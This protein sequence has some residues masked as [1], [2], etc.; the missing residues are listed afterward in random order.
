MFQAGAVEP[1]EPQA[2]RVVADQDVLVSAFRC[3]SRDLKEA[4]SPVGGQVGVQMEVSIDLPV[5]YDALGDLRIEGTRSRRNPKETVSLVDLGFGQP[6]RVDAGQKR[7]GVPIGSCH[8]EQLPS[9]RGWPDQVNVGGCAFVGLEHDLPH[10][11]L[12]D[13]PGN[14]SA[15]EKLVSGGDIVDPGDQIDGLHPLFPA[16]NGSGCLHRPA[17]MTEKMLADGVRQHLGLK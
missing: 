13:K 17:E 16:P 4:H 6:F 12:T 15:F 3:L 1:S 7:T 11:P 2:N 10:R 5:P 14:G 9:E 8:L